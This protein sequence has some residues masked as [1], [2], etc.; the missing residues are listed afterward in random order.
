MMPSDTPPAM[1]AAAD[2]W[3]VITV[4]MQQQLKYPVQTCVCVCV[5][6]LPCQT[7][8]PFALTQLKS[9]NCPAL[10]ARLV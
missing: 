4:C 3:H 6:G 1:H 9:L 8:L 5:W 2:S 7:A 10:R